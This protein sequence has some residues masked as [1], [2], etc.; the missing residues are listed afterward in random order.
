MD[1]SG[2]S[3]GRLDQG[4]ESGALMFFGE[5]EEF[6]AMVS[7]KK[8]AKK[9]KDRPLVIKKQGSLLNQRASFQKLSPHGL[10]P[11][12]QILKNRFI[13]SKNIVSE[14]CEG[15]VESPFHHLGR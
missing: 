7:V 2:K 11:F 10:N 1:F 6:M 9:E 4:D 15:L 5:I 14:P 12:A 13:D 8:S 3:N